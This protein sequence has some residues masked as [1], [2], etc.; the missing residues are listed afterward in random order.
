MATGTAVLTVV[1]NN[2]LHF[3]R[4]ML[5]SVRRVHPD[6]NLFCVIVDTDLDHADALSEEFEVI[7]LQDLGLPLGDSFFFQYNVLELNTAVKPWALAYLLNRRYANVI[8]IDPDIRLYRGMNEV[9]EGL[10]TGADIIVTPHLL[11]RITDQ[12]RPSE[13]D[14]RRAGTYNFGF[15]AIRNSDNTA[16][17]ID[18][19]QSKLTHDCVVALED[20]IF[21]DQS[22]IDL[23]PGLFDNVQVLRHPGYN[24]AYWNIAQREVRG[25]RNSWT[26]NGAPLVFFHY[27]G[28]DPLNPA[29]FSKHQDRFTL[30]TLGPAKQLVKAYAQ[31]LVD[32][33][34]R[35]Y[36]TIPYG[37]DLFDD[38][39]RLPPFFHKLYRENETLREALGDA[40]YAN[41]SILLETARTVEGEEI[42]W[43]MLAL[44]SANTDVQTAFPIDTGEG[45]RAWR[46]WFAH[47]GAKHF[48]ETVMRYH[49]ELISNPNMASAAGSTAAITRA[50]ASPSSHHSDDVD[51]IRA[52]FYVILGRFPDPG[53]V[54]TYSRIL[55]KPNGRFRMWKAVA[56]SRENRSKLGWR[57]RAWAG[58]RIALA[59]NLANRH[60]W[61]SGRSRGPAMAAP[62]SPARSASAPGQAATRDLPEVANLAEKHW[63]D[64][65]I[66]HLRNKLPP[67]WLHEAEQDSHETG[68]W[69]TANIRLPLPETLAG[70]TVRIE[71]SYDGELVA[72]QT[73]KTEGAFAIFLRDRLL[74]LG[75]S[76]G[77]TDFTFAFALPEALGSRP[78]LT[79]LSEGHFIPSEIGLSADDREL[80]LKLKKVSIDHTDIFD[81]ARE[82]P[83]LMLGKDT[84]TVPGIN[85]IGYIK[86][87]LGIGEAAR[88]LGA[89]ARSAEIPYSVIDMGFQT[90]SR[91]TDGTALASA[92]AAKQPIDILYVNA[93]QTPSTL[94][95]LRR[96]DHDAA[97][98]IGAWHWEQ[99]LLPE[100]YLGSFAGLNEVWV[101]TSFVQEAVASIAPIPVVK[102]PNA[103]EFEIPNNPRRA[104]FGLPSRAF[105]VLMMY[106]FHSY[107]YRKNP[108]AAIAA[109]RLAAKGHNDAVLVIKT[110]NASIHQQEYDALKLSIADLGNVV[111]IDQPLARAEVYE[112]QACCDALLSLHRAE[113]F[114]LAPAELMFLGKPVIAT[115]WSGNMD[116]MTPMNSYPVNY[117]LEPLT[118]AHGP[119]QVGQLWAEA[120][121]D[122]ASWCLKQ[123]ME[124]GEA[125]AR[126]RQLAAADIRANHSFNAVG[127]QIRARLSLLADQHDID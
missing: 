18:W 29:P 124:G 66:D 125:V 47:D 94:N 72:R 104:R 17:F 23:V 21:V 127:Q 4:T 56:M 36:G 3:A 31:E 114:G 38:G 109:F 25:D 75:K 67:Y 50:T 33:G 105:L 8:Y 64:H 55:R 1:S 126:K 39:T 116:F 110:L 120:D 122:H 84:G 32:N 96:I 71:G 62:K 51:R 73:G 30:E 22:W 98:R 2:Y 118:R 5:K 115:G 61:P 79:I 15:C 80:A 46:A 82:N 123:A 40:P 28:L 97:L 103:V 78:H 95:H 68:Y 92:V 44:W 121:I 60:D 45:V 53:A 100:R 107:Q 63:Y 86:A 52:V 77:I 76:V 91:Q 112:L 70:R 117:T 59:D 87:E 13:L 10:S 26:V 65:R 102:I 81:C 57:S 113:G 101:P 106:D 20:G 19:W 111:Y 9:I 89:A 58:L 49:R 43:A 119:Y 7:R 34:V 69:T 24:V 14:I 83:V 90:A 11:A 41:P 42:T 88:S 37:F 99:P 93:D 48:S 54:T 74:Y 12:N 6:A 27:S 108:D 35:R 85:L 16:N